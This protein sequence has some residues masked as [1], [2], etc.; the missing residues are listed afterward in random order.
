MTGQ[1]NPHGGVLQTIPLGG[2]R[3]FIYSTAALEAAITKGEVREVLAFKVRYIVDA[4]VRQRLGVWKIVKKRSKPCRLSSV[5]LADA[6]G[7]RGYRAALDWLIGR[8][9][10]VTDGIYIVGKEAKGYAITKRGWR[11]GPVPIEMTD[12]QAGIYEKGRKMLRKES[13]RRRNAENVPLDYLHL[14]L[15]R[16][17]FDEAEVARYFAEMPAPATWEEAERIHAHAY[18]AALV[19]G[20]AWTFHRCAAGRLH[21][22]ITNLP[23]ALRRLLTYQGDDL[24]EVDAASCQ[25]FLASTL[26]P[27]GEEERRRYLADVKMPGFY[28]RLGEA[29]RWAGSQDE[30]KKEIIKVC[31]YGSRSQASGP[32]WEAFAATYPVLAEIIFNGKEDSK[33]RDKWQGDSR[34]AMALQGAEAKVFIDGALRRIAIEMPGV[35]ALPLHDG[36]LTTARNAEEVKAILEE[37]FIREVGEAPTIKNKAA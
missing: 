32:V 19:A 26:Y 21:Y 1:R 14:H 7:T 24:V 33:G 10:I 35:P 18:S 37:E 11:G 28:E 17:Q 36:F 20:R 5:H 23:R 8:G 2:A 25:P 4:I 31:F 30:L 3:R 6:L 12:R 34:L 29:A 16:L 15:G 9:L 27:V 22:Q 13:N